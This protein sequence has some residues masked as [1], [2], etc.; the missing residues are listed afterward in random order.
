MYFLVIKSLGTLDR[1]IMINKHATDYDRNA[2]FNYK[3]SWLKSKS[4]LFYPTRIG[5]SDTADSESRGAASPWHPVFQLT[6]LSLGQ[7]GASPAT[8]AHSLRVTGCLVEGN[9]VE[10]GEPFSRA[11]IGRLL[12]SMSPA[13]GQGDK[14]QE[15]ECKR[16]SHDRRCCQSWD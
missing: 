14:E 2:I 8:E 13:I 6:A 7:T 4:K 10:E 1:I 11:L 15:G 9:N 3:Y 16:K 12:S 5:D